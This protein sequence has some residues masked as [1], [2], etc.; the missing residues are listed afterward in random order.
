MSDTYSDYPDMECPDCGHEWEDG[1]SV[2]EG[3]IV[4]C[5]ECGC[6]SEVTEVDTVVKIRLSK[7]ETKR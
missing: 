2:G 6:E 4:E 3:Q 1:D 7:V 5:P